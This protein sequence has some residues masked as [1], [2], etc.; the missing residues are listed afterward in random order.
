MNYNFFQE[1]ILFL[2][3]V[4]I[5]LFPSL[6]IIVLLQFSFAGYGGDFLF[7]YFFRFSG[8]SCLF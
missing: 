1:H 2:F 7:L 6:P 5:Y 8:F 3:A 4:D